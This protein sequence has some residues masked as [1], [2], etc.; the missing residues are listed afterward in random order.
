MAN[1]KTMDAKV[2][3]VVPTEVEASPEI[4]IDIP[5]PTSYKAKEK[6]PSELWHC[7]EDATGIGTMAL[8]LPS[9]CLIMTVVD[10]I[11]PALQYVPGI[12]YDEA[13]K[14]FSV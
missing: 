12:H 11:Q 4:T 2:A 9:G 13:N 8:N 6:V 5:T 1:K 10:Q 14:R 3:A 7:V